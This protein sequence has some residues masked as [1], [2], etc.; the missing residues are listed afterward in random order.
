MRA[1]KNKTQKRQKV[2]NTVFTYKRYVCTLILH[3]YRI[4]IY[5]S[6]VFCCICIVSVCYV[7]TSVSVCCVRLLCCECISVTPLMDSVWRQ[8]CTTLCPLVFPGAHMFVLTEHMF[9]LNKN[10]L[11]IL[12]QFLKPRSRIPVPNI[13]IFS[14]CLS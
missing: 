3:T 1:K 4:Y 2:K 9:G 14:S 10:L 13:H 6:I 12:P 8:L 5:I 7:Y 11:G